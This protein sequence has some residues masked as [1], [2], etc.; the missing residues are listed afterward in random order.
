MPFTFVVAKEVVD[1]YGKE[2]LNHPVGTGAFVLKNSTKV[3][4]L[5]IQKP[6][7]S[8]KSFILPRL[9]KSSKLKGS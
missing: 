4:K 8:E 3:I 1:H 5:F 2:F 7:I 6:K 9:R